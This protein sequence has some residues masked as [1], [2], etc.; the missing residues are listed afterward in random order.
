MR[1]VHV[2][3]ARVDVVD[4]KVHRAPV[5]SFRLE[6]HADMKLGVFGKRPAWDGLRARAPFA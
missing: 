4:V 1:C 3:V 6:F 5:G 2:H